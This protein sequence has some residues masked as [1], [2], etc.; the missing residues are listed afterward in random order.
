MRRAESP[1]KG[2]IVIFLKNLNSQLIY[3][4]REGQKRKD[5]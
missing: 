1:E 5:Y 4:E 3:I 2:K